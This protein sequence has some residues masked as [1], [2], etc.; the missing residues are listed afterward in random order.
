MTAADA[1][2]QAVARRARHRFALIAPSGGATYAAERE[3]SA[4]HHA[5]RHNGEHGS[6]PVEWARRPVHQQ[7]RMECVS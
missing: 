5:I 2:G 4:G 7:G 6:D 3:M 1:G